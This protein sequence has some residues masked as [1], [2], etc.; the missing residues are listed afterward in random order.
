MSSAAFWSISTS[1]VRRAFAS[2][3]CSSPCSSAVQVRI[4][5]L[6]MTNRSWP[7]RTSCVSTARISVRTPSRGARTGSAPPSGASTNAQRIVSGSGSRIATASTTANSTIRRMASAEVADIGRLRANKSRPAWPSTGGPFA[8]V[9]SLMSPSCSPSVPAVSLQSQLLAAEVEVQPAAGH[10]LVVRAL[11]DDPAPSRA[12]R[13]GRRCGSCSAGARSR[14]T[15]GRR[16]AAARFSWM[17]HSDSVS[18]ALVASSK[19]STGG[20]S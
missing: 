4:C 20:W 11:L 1:A 10:Q 2:S 8:G 5:S 15:S 14:T 9:V 17:A 18:S 16:A 7:L 12:R 13:S 19:M 6:R 3:S